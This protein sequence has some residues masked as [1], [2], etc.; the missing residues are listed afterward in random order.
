[1]ID[2]GMCRQE[3]DSLAP[4]DQIKEIEKQ[5]ELTKKEKKQAWKGKENLFNS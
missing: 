5:I 2:F 4:K 1:M 3:F